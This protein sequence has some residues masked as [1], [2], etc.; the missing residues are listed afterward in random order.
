MG[1]TCYSVPQARIP[2]HP[3][4]LLVKPWTFVHPIHLSAFVEAREEHNRDVS[5][6]TP[7]CRGF[8]CHHLKALGRAVSARPFL[9]RRHARACVGVAQAYV[10]RVINATTELAALGQMPHVAY[11]YGILLRSWA[12]V[13][14]R[15]RQ[16]VHPPS[17]ACEGGVEESWFR[18]RASGGRAKCTPRAEIAQRR[19]GL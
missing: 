3:W 13:V 1:E 11:E 2:L 5:H 18:W 16:L 7:P 10:G 8:F 14:V 9:R 4:V 19:P 12:A 17:R 6:P 15:P